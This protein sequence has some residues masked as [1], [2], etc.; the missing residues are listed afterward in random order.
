MMI[1]KLGGFSLASPPSPPD[2]VAAPL[3]IKE[4]SFR[5]DP[6]EAVA[7]SN[8]LS[9]VGSSNTLARTTT[10]KTTIAIYAAAGLILA[11]AVVFGKKG[12]R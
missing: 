6:I 1:G 11:V 8:E 12:G 10:S 3:L 5:Y 9:S 2:A 4:S 7:V